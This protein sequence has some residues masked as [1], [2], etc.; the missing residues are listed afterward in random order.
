M[1]FLR[2]WMQPFHYRWIITKAIIKYFTTFFRIIKI[3][4]R[5]RSQYSYIEIW[6][7]EWAQSSDVKTSIHLKAF[8]LFPFE[9]SAFNVSFHCFKMG[10]MVLNRGFILLH[11]NNDDDNDNNDE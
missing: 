6:L 11:N 8:A 7:T 2:Q 4:R 3:N 9:C 5:K 1:L 10:K